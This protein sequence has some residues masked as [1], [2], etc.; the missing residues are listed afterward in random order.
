MMGF[1]LAQSFSFYSR[2]L[3][4]PPDLLGAMGCERKRGSAWKLARKTKTEEKKTMV[5]ES[6]RSHGSGLNNPDAARC[7]AVPLRAVN[8]RNNRAP[9][10][11]ASLP[12]SW[13]FPLLTGKWVCAANRHVR[14]HACR[15]RAVMVPEPH[16]GVP[17]GALTIRLLP[18]RGS[19]EQKVGLS[20]RVRLGAARRPSPRLGLPFCARG[21]LS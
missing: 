5:G 7:R 13:P 2:L 14:S 10:C 16:N 6:D 15:A 4:P 20:P 17:K 19:L 21:L 3:L 8:A 11:D 12:T 1:H 9:R 18:T